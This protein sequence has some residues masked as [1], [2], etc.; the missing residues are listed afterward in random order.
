MSLILVSFT[1]LAVGA[2]V[3]I[4]WLNSRSAKALPSISDNE[5]LLMYK[6]NFDTPDEAVLQERTY[7]AKTLGLP[8]DKLAPNQTLA[9]LEKYSRL[10]FHVA[11]GDLHNDLLS[12]SAS[13]TPKRAFPTSVGEVIHELA[14]AHRQS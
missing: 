3:Y 1:A 14:Q 8:R 6:A 7:L 11:L 2:V 13:Q 9:D 12:L 5:F 10:G 4:N